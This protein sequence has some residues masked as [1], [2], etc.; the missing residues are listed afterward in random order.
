MKKF[1]LLFIAFV[2]VAT[3]NLE[4]QNAPSPCSELFISEYSCGKYNNRALEIYNPTATAISLANYRLGRNDNGLTTIYLSEFPP[5]AT[6]QPYKTYVVVCDK[7][8]TTQYGVGLEYPIFDGYQAWDTCKISGVVQIDPTTGKPDFCVKTD[9]SSSQLPLRANVY[10]DFL[11]L[12]CRANGYINPVYATNR[13][14]YFNGNDAVLLFKGATPDI[15]NFTNLIDMVGIYNDPGMVSAKSWKDYLGRDLTLDRTL[16]RKQA[17]K[18]GTGLIAY[19]RN[20]TFRYAEYLSFANT[21]GTPGF[22]NLGSHTCDCQTTGAPISGKRTCN[23]TLITGSAE[24]APAELK[25]FPNP[26]VSGSIAIEADGLIE[27]IRV[28]DL[29]GRLIET[30][31]IPF[32][33]ESVQLTLQSIRT[34]IYFIQITTTDKRIG[35]QKLVVQH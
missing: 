4:A 33:S 7:R 30:Q 15:I 20:D 32:Q 34:G 18:N 3:A 16:I 22:Q 9:G 13:T 35:V 21:N 29:V 12:Q 25:I 19:A 1:L 2:A 17:V 24:V 28:F 5:N 14:M 26:S 8:D 11:D 6:V 10:R 27:N 31:T 23:G